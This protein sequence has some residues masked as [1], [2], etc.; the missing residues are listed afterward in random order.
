MAAVASIAVVGLS[1]VPAPSIADHVT[2]SRTIR[3][4]QT[5]Q[6]EEQA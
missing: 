3:C 6:D 5:S 2:R 1:A 4:A